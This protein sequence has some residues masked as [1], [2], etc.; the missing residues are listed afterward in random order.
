MHV[1]YKQWHDDFTYIDTSPV[2]GENVWIKEI[3]WLY[4]TLNK[5]NNKIIINLINKN[6]WYEKNLH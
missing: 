5:N 2:K 3:I 6:S 1:P 4:M